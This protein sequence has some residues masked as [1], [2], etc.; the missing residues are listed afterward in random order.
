M[1]WIF[2]K[3]E[4]KGKHFSYAVWPLFP[5]FNITGKALNN[6]PDEGRKRRRRTRPKRSLI[7]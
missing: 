2:A 7:L 3:E 5:G 6:Q 1:S 4:K